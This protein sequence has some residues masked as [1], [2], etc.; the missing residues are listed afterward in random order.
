MVGALLLAAAPLLCWADRRATKARS[1]PASVA[2]EM[3]TVAWQSSG[4]GWVLLFGGLTG[5]RR[6]RKPAER[7]GWR[8]P[9]FR[10]PVLASRFF[11]IAWGAPVLL[12]ICLWTPVYAP[13]NQGGVR[14]PLSPDAWYLLCRLYQGAFLLVVLGMM[15]W[16]ILGSDFRRYKK[17]ARLAKHEP[18]CDECGYRITGLISPRCPECGAP[19]PD[20]LP[21]AHL[22]RDEPA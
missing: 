6:F 13:L 21:Q 18:L 14:D 1:D 4:T 20:A 9:R 17:L 16:S 3:R 22:P 7:T 19:I 2:S 5:W 10:V 8:R 12:A 11:M 15:T